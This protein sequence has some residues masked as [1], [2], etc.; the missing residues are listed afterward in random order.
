MQS[1]QHSDGQANLPIQ[2][3]HFFLAVH[4]GAGRHS[5]KMEQRYKEGA[6]S[7]H[8]RRFTC[9]FTSRALLGTCPATRCHKVLITYVCQRGLYQ[10]VEDLDK[11]CAAEMKLACHKGAEALRREGVALDAVVAAIAALEV[12]SEDQNNML[13]WL[14]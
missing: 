9:T 1:R 7:S 12:R 13:Q 2:D 14:L 6:P 11:L 5:H 8:A 4:I 10:Q 3:P